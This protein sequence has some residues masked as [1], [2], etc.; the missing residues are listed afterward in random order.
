MY[1]TIL[2][3]IFH[4]YPMYHKIGDKAYKEGLEN[5][6]SLMA[7]VGQPHH[8]FKSIHVAG[9][10]GKGSVSNLL[11]SFFQEAG[12]KVG[13]FTS[14][15]LVDFK[16]RIK[17]NGREI[18]EDEV[19]DF[20]ALYRESFQP[21]SPSFFEITVA[22]AFDYFRKKK[23]DYAI[24]EV[25]LGGRLDATNIIIP[26]LSIITNISLEHT[27]LLGDSIEKIAH[28]KAGI[29]K[30]GVPVVI[31][32]YDKESLPVFVSVAKD[33][34]ATLLTTEKIRIITSKFEND[35][36]ITHQTVSIFENDR[37][38]A[39]NVKSPLLASYQMKNIATFAKSA[40]YLCEKLSIPDKF[41]ISAIE[42]VIKNVHFQGRWQI[43]NRHPLT[44]CD[45]A[46]NLAG[47]VEIVKQL[48][49]TDYRY[50]HVVLGFANDKDVQAMLSLLPRNN[51]T[52]YLCQANSARAMEVSIVEKMAQTFSLKTVN[53]GSVEKSYNLAKQSAK[54]EDLI[55]ICGSNFVIG[56]LLGLV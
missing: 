14:P 38:I 44:I 56:E 25:G 37:L 17:V 47:F 53:G 24:V 19:V 45:T 3:E 34:N 27:A 22:L 42:N 41:I 49:E 39:E 18:S 52:Y 31:G 10:N 11:A 28:E 54:K 8:H 48:K 6:E 20:F 32:E 23:V 46:H 16:E 33:K 12:Y 2:D 13:L 35:T 51:A 9:T 4:A 21:I 36:P 55:L 15:H 26:E 30:K 29:I 1:Q 7:V 5:I 43:L 40:L 50:L